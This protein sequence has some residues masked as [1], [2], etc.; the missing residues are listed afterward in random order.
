ATWTQMVQSLYIG[1]TGRGSLI[2]A[3][4]FLTIGFVFLFGPF[5]DWIADSGRL[6]VLWSALP[7]ILSI[8]AA[9]KMTAVIWVGQRLF[10]QRLVSDRTL[11]G[12]AVVWCLVVLALYGVL[13]W[14][15]DA[16]HIPHYLLMLIAILAI[17]IARLSAAPVSLATSRHR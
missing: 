17:P 4:V 10:R 11:V 2:K 12:G 6:G 13:A 1:L 3:S 5:F 14:L 15:L 7:V 8:L 16:P 9:A